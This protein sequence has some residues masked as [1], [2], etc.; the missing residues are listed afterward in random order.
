[1]KF[2]L[3]LLL[4]FFSLNVL[5]QAGDDPSSDELLAGQLLSQGE[6]EK[7]ALLYEELFEE[8][9]SAL[10]YN[11][12]LRCL[13]ELEDYKKA[14]RVIKEQIKEYPGRARFKVD[15]GYLFSLE[16]NTRKAGRQLDDLL[17]EVAHHPS[18]ISDLAN[19]FLFRNFY[20]YALKTYQK[21]RKIFGASVPYNIQMAEIYEQKGDF[22]NMMKEYV[23]LAVVDETMLNQ[24]QGILQD[25]I[26]QDPEFIKADALKGVLIQG[27]QKNPQ[28]TLY[29]ELL[30]W[31]SVQ[32]KDYEMALR[33]AKVLDRRLQQEGRLV[34]DVSMLG[35]SAKAF[36]VAHEGFEYL[37]KQGDLSPFYL[38]ATIGLLNTKYQQATSGFEIDYEMLA[39]VENA[40]ERNINELGINALTV[41]LIRNLAN[42][43]AFYLNNPQEASQLL[44]SIIDLPN[45]SARLKAECR[46]ELGDILLLEGELWDAH[47]LY[48]QVDKT[49]RDDPLAHEARF[50]NARLSFYM[51]EFKWARAQLDVLKSATSRLVANDAMELSMFIQDNLGEDTISIPLAMFGR[52]RMHTFM[53]NF[54]QALQVLDSI[55]IA[56]DSHQI[57]DNVMQAKARL[58]VKTGQF[59]VADSLLAEITRRFPEGLLA[60][61]ALFQRAHLQESVFKNKELAMELYQRLIVDYPGSLNTL[62]ARNRFR[63]LRGDSTTEEEYYLHHNFTP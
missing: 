35:A 62:A 55:S 13:F 18:A 53:N 20:D 5:A 61:D 27:A 3:V 32:Q 45:V 58:Y 56:Y 46:I 9:P 4:S 26:N 34:L 10:L 8:N 44:Q 50:K 30:L 54:D 14:E 15:L 19:A 31:L 49:F 23:E 22:S 21:G 12:Y 59:E 24:V 38:D 37:I 33:Q 40:Y 7:A 11:N 16:G 43:K 25:A 41:S 29:A 28:Q 42:L 17:D 6:Y 52:A 63:F 57:I 48:A 47:L 39:E 1:M 2:V 51:G 36:E 60:S